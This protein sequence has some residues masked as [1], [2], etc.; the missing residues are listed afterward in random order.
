MEVIFS[1]LQVSHLVR[2]THHVMTVTVTVYMDLLGNNVNM[3]CMYYI[4]GLFLHYA[5]C[6]YTYYV[7]LVW[8][9]MQYIVCMHV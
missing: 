8:Y 2:T 3:V 6:A 7:I 5:Y 1:A 9:C 4:I